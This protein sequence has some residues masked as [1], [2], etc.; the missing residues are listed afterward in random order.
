MANVNVRVVGHFK[1][2]SGKTLNHFGTVQYNLSVSLL[3][4]APTGAS[5]PDPA[6]I[7]SV[8][9]SDSKV[10]GGAAAFHVDGLAILDREHGS[11]ILS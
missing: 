7:A 9:S 1:D 8:M 10:P 6:S 5:Y 11:G 2:A 4:G 3:G